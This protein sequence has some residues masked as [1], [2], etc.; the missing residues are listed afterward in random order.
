MVGIKCT[1]LRGARE[2]MDG[3]AGSPQTDVC[4]G[5]QT[6]IP[7]TFRSPGRTCIQKQR[8]DFAAQEFRC[9]V[10]RS[11]N[12]ARRTHQRKHNRFRTVLENIQEQLNTCLFGP[13]PICRVVIRPGE[14]CTGS[15]SDRNRTSD[16][17]GKLHDRNITRVTRHIEARRGRVQ[18]FLCDIQNHSPQVILGKRN[19]GGEIDVII[20]VLRGMVQIRDMNKG[21]HRIFSAPGANRGCD[22]RGMQSRNGANAQCE[23]LTTVRH[24]LDGCEGELRSKYSQRTKHARQ[25]REDGR[26]S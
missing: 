12:N 17:M 5:I 15:G 1:L 4:S 6:D 20:R 11:R 13:R 7:F 14:R 24:A 9:P 8:T 2:P 21:D 16:D 25:R 3:K 18:E 26:L 22:G 23:K 10:K 19:D